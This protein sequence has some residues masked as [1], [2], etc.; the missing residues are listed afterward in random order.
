MAGYANRRR[1]RD[2]AILSVRKISITLEE[3][4]IA[5]VDAIAK[6][7]IRSRSQQ[8]AHLIGVAM[9]G[10][11]LA[12]SD[13][14]ELQALHRSELARTLKELAEPSDGRAVRRG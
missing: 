11:A 4:L 10:T 14:E 9:A 7:Q 12:A 13:L 1:R 2:G 6:A 5:R 8:I 3:A